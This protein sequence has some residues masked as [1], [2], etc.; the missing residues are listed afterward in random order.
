MLRVL[1]CW[2]L[3]GWR[4]AWAQIAG[5]LRYYRWWL[6]WNLTWYGGPVTVCL[7]A[8]SR[9][10]AWLDRKVEAELDRRGIGYV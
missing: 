9:F 5:P 2:R 3:W 10:A 4:M 8:W 6:W 7:V 1:A